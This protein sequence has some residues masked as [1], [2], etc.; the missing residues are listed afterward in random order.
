MAISSNTDGRRRA[1]IARIDEPP[2]PDM[3]VFAAIKKM[4]NV[5]FGEDNNQILRGIQSDKEYYKNRIAAIGNDV[6]RVHTDDRIWQDCIGGVAEF[7]AVIYFPLVTITN[8]SH[9]SHEIVDLWVRFPLTKNGFVNGLQGVRTSVTPEEQIAQ[10]R[11]SHLGRSSGDS[12]GDFCLGSGPLAMMI[13]MMRSSFKPEQFQMFLLNIREYVKWESISGTPYIRMNTI[14]NR[15]GTIN[16]DITTIDGR[17]KQDYIY[18]VFEF[19]KSLT[20]DVLMSN[21]E[22]KLDS[23]RL[24]VTISDHLENLITTYFNDGNTLNLDQYMCYKNTDGKYVSGVIADVKLPDQH[25]PIL[26]FKGEPIFLK[27]NKQENVKKNTKY[28]HPV[29]KC[30]LEARLTN[31][32]NTSNSA[33]SGTQV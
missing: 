14:K 22:I 31:Y 1:L 4:M 8:D 13:P 21:I 12:W 32:F 33:Y 5:T 9:E 23:N 29:F 3:E 26:T 19:I 7:T 30:E 25:T 2:E 10:Y 15:T 27:F 16:S 6:F 17:Q 20:H 18:Y 24:I 28:L 11:H